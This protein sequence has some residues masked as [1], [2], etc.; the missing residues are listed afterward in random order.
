[1][2]EEEAGELAGRV[3]VMIVVF[4]LLAGA[5]SWGIHQLTSL[6]RD[7]NLDKAPEAEAR[8]IK[9]WLNSNSLILI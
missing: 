6:N 7:G 5:R 4:C 1:M 3:E 9:D 2:K 8:E